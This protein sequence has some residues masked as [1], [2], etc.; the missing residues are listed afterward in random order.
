MFLKGDVYESLVF[1]R[2]LTNQHQTRKTQVYKFTGPAFIKMLQATYSGKPC[3]WFCVAAIVIFALV[4]FPAARSQ[5]EDGNQ[6]IVTSCSNRTA[7]KETCCN[8]TD[9]LLCSLCEVADGNATCKITC[10][11]VKEANTCA[12]PP[13]P[14]TPSCANKNV[15]DCCNSTDGLNCSLCQQEAGG[16]ATCQSQ[17]G[18]GENDKCQNI[19]PFTTPGPSP[20]TSN[21]TTTGTT[22]TTTGTTTPGKSGGSGQSF[23][24]ASF[25]GGIILSLG[26]VAIIFFGL[27]FYKARKDQNYHTL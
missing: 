24:G 18:A 13:G 8:S 26:I 1:L 22:S 5:S 21:A 19:E 17:C 3:S 7:E 12:A 2:K 4:T 10:D 11:A 15:S 23:D 16:D 25:V 9:G 6:D 27:K 20:T 14:V